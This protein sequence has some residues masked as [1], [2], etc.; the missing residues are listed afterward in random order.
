MPSFNEVALI[1]LN[2]VHELA[3]VLL[4]EKEGGLTHISDLNQAFD[5][6]HFVLLFPDGK[7]GWTVELKKTDGN[8][9]T[10]MEFYNYHLQFRDEDKKFNTSWNNIRPEIVF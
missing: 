1:K 8:S 7:P 5:P 3:D 2:D 9:L 6:L 4:R 10:P